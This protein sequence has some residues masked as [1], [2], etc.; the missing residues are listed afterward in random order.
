M[1]METRS[2][3]S[4]GLL[5]SN[6]GTTSPKLLDLRRGSKGRVPLTQYLPNGMMVETIDVQHDEKEAKARAKAAAK[7]KRSS[8]QSPNDQRKSYAP[9]IKSING[10]SMHN[11]RQERLPSPTG[12]F[13]PPWMADERRRFSSPMLSNKYRN[14]SSDNLAINKQY[15]D[16]NQDLRMSSYSMMTPPLRGFRS[17]SPSRQSFQTGVS[18]RE[19]RGWRKSL[20][21]RSA[22]ASVASFPQSGS[23]ME[24][25]LGMSQDRH[26]PMPAGYTNDQRDIGNAGLNGAH[27]MHAPG[28]TWPDNAS[29]PGDHGGIN[30]DES[31]EAAKEKKHK[32][33]RFQ[34]LFNS[35]LG[36]HHN[37][38]KVSSKSRGNAA[39]DQHLN[40]DH[41]ARN[42]GEDHPQQQYPTKMKKPQTSF[43]YAAAYHDDYSEPLA[44][45]PPLSYL[46]GQQ[47][48][49]RTYSSS[50]QSSYNATGSVA[51]SPRLHGQEVGTVQQNATRP[52]SLAVPRNNAN[53]SNGFISPSTS[54]SDLSRNRPSSVT[55]WRSSSNKTTGSPQSPRELLSDSFGHP[56]PAIRQASFEEM[57]SGMRAVDELDLHKDVDSYQLRKEK[58]LPALPPG[59][60][61]GRV[62]PSHGPDLGLHRHMP[63]IP[64]EGGQN[65]GV[66]SY[67]AAAH[68]TAPVVHE[69]YGDVN[70]STYQHAA[71]YP[72]TGPEWEYNTH[73]REHDYDGTNSIGKASKKTKMRSR[74]FSFGNK[75]GRSS[76]SPPPLQSNPHPPQETYFAKGYAPHEAALQA[77]VRDSGDMVAY[78]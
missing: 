21:P 53:S 45:P 72:G 52:N 69:I 40:K 43:N 64:Y 4:A 56:L 22:S 67:G 11:N 47:P 27:V 1:S 41:V 15:N 49:T 62:S 3:M 57:A 29:E 66:I 78:K 38:D 18:Q 54:S 25:H 6:G 60:Y 19:S 13:A 17:P 36:T 26:D 39:L 44:P 75:K 32:K 70:G 9:S 31:V 34:K 20:W 68:A 55:S 65:N 7:S 48:H 24:M 71:M 76:T 77:V 8:S 14:A 35:L 42:G 2:S 58:S 46:T 10:L 61:D 63:N 28:A 5:A 12:S 74:L 33:K 59:E 30:P 23:M 51:Q 73:T 16:P 37:A 50:S